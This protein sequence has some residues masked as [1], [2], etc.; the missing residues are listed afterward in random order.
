MSSLICWVVK[1]CFCARIQ[2]PIHRC[3]RSCAGIH[4]LTFILQTLNGSK[5]TFQGMPLYMSLLVVKWTCLNINNTGLE[6]SWYQ[7]NTN[8]T[9]DA[10]CAIIII[11][12]VPFCESLLNRA[13]AFLYLNFSK[14]SRM[15]T[16][17]KPSVLAT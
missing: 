9:R 4:Y 15:L 12:L 6:L 5:S 14:L 17:A 1:M 7:P 2:T 13:P 3:L 11:A 16:L 8:D 10:N